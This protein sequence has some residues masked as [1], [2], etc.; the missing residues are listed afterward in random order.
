LSAVVALALVVLLEPALRGVERIAQRDVDV[1]VGRILGARSVD[2]DLALRHEDPNPDR[3]GRTTGT[4]N[5]LS[6]YSM[7]L[8]PAHRSLIQDID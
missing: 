2:H 5:G 3:I 6:L 7:Q 8:D 4:G 1:L